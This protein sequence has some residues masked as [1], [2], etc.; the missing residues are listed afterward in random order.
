MDTVRP[1]AIGVRSAW[2]RRGRQPGFARLAPPRWADT[3]R[4]LM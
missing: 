2:A 4:D 3:V 1:R